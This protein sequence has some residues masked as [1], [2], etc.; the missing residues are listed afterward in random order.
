M[1]SIPDDD[2]RITLDGFVSS[3]IL[4]AYD[5]SDPSSVYLENVGLGGEDQWE[6]YW[7]E[8]THL[9]LY[10]STS[11]GHVQ[12]TFCAIQNGFK[13]HETLTNMVISP[14][15]QIVS[16]LHQA[17]W[18]IQEGAATITPHLLKN[19]FS[20]NLIHPGTYSHLPQ[21][22]ANAATLMAKAVG[23][24]LPV[25]FARYGYVAVNAVAQ[26]CLNTRLLQF[27][28]EFMWNINR[29][30]QGDTTK[31]F[32]HLSDGKNHPSNR[33]YRLISK[34]YDDENNE[35]PNALKLAFMS[36]IKNLEFVSE[37]EGGLKIEADTQEKALQLQDVF[38][39]NVMDI[40]QEILPDLFVYSRVSE[41]K[42]DIR[43][44]YSAVESSDWVKIVHTDISEDINARAK[45]EPEIKSL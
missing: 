41:M 12:Q 21:R 45:F 30:G 15:V 4:G 7:H 18:E 42:D 31:F 38:N 6:A 1:I 24:L 13:G 20:L 33:L 3:K 22:Y 25:E 26:F 34:L 9:Q 36:D 23:G 27:A 17:S 19:S 40:L 39:W 14:F 11:F 16:L 44:F 32:E 5:P 29:A 2:S 28:T 10:T 37:F 8:C 35:I 43:K